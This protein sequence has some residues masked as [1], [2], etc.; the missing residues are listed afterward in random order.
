MYDN[1]GYL[2][3]DTGAEM[4]RQS[5]TILA[6]RDV[7]EIVIDDPR[8]IDVVVKPVIAPELESGTIQGLKALLAHVK[9][10][11]KF[12]DSLLQ[13]LQQSLNSMV[14]EMF[15]SVMGEA[16]ASGCYSLEEYDYMQPTRAAC[17][18]MLIGRKLD[19]G[20]VDTANLGM[21]A[22]LMNLGD[23][24][25]TAEEE[26]DWSTPVPSE[27]SD[28]PTVAGNPT[29]EDANHKHPTQTA[30]FLMKAKRFD[31]ETIEGA[32]HHHE[33]WDG[34]GYPSGLSREQISPFAR[35]IAIADTFYELVSTRPDRPAYM[36][37]EAV[38]FILAY[39]GE[40]FD[41]RLVD[42]FT[43]IVPL[44]PTG[45]TVKLN[46]GEMGVVSDAN[47]G[48]IGRPIV[49]VCSHGGTNLVRRPYDINLISPEHQN[50]LVSEV[51]P[52]LEPV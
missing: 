24:L 40:L 34:S 43:K 18:A 47:I 26:A 48:F 36:P 42:L 4:N 37:H 6:S 33:R 16:N 31:P 21:A 52:Y 1:R 38:E 10:H 44:Y 27:E 25:V 22:L 45:I 3:L 11:G 2:L 41:P 29:G 14:R 30:G 9:T 17:L 19:S 46:T 23:S 5:L 50:Q 49:R 32:L 7:P 51:D 12:D 28:E 15:P 20:I 35:I 8:T 39:S 13:A